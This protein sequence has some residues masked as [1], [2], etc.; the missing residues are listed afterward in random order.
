MPARQPK[1]KSK[2]IRQN[3][4][5][6]ATSA[7]IVPE[8]VDYSNPPPQFRR[9]RPEREEEAFK[10]MNTMLETGFTVSKNPCLQG[11]IDEVYRYI[12]DGVRIPL[13][14]PMPEID[15]TATGVLAI[16][17]REQVVVC[18]KVGCEMLETAGQSS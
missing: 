2:Q 15:R 14:I 6:R 10:I 7:V 17:R 13:N 18:L 5:R 11:L 8:E 4:Q 1:Y 9:S 3:K 12:R 16:D